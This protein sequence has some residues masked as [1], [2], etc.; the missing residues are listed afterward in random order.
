[1]LTPIDFL[2][3]CKTPGSLRLL[4]AMGPLLW[5][6]VFCNFT[7]IIHSQITTTSQTSENEHLI[8]VNKKNTGTTT[9]SDPDPTDSAIRS[10]TQSGFLD[11]GQIGSTAD[12]TASTDS[13][14]TASESEISTG[15]EVP[16][17]ATVSKPLPL[18]GS[19]PTPITDGR[20][21]NQKRCSVLQ[22]NTK[23]KL[24]FRNDILPVCLH[25]PIAFGLTRTSCVC[26]ISYCQYTF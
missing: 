18:A 1:M 2:S 7:V 9:Q 19:L 21:C 23:F 24:A 17:A 5:A 11:S 22:K 8:Y 6:L 20:F 10:T 16:K 4:G 12:P 14:P 13:N 26:G 25:S 15:K 3:G